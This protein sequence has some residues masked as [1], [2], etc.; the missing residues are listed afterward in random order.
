MFPA[1]AAAES[2]AHDGAPIAARFAE[3][4]ER[5]SLRDF[6]VVYFGNDWFAENRTSS[7]HVAAQLARRTRVLYVDCP[8]LRAPKATG[9]DLRKLQRKLLMA[10]S[11]PRQV[12]ERMWHITMPQVPFRRLPAI[13]DIN[14]ATG[15]F[16]VRRAMKQLGFDRTVSWFAVP[17]PG[18]LARTL[19]E[20]LAVYYCIDDY[21]ALPDVDAAAV[22]RMDTHLLRSADQVF[23]A[24]ELLL[25]SKRNLNASAVHAPHGVDVELFRNASDPRFAAVDAVRDLPRPVIGFY[26]LIES[27]IDLD[28]IAFLAQQRPQWTFLM[29]GRLA[30]DPGHLRDLPNVVFAGAQ[31]YESLPRWAKAFDVAI[32]PYRLT[33][34][35][36]NSN[37]L[38]L[39]EYLAT[40]KPVVAVSAP[41]IDR[42]SAHVRIAADSRQFLE[43]IEAALASDTPAQ[44]QARMQS[45]ADMGW[46]AR[47]DDVVRVVEER[48]TERAIR[49]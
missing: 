25:E 47:I 43:H 38:K 45:V 33:R 36:V 23:V 10:A 3:A 40:G 29:I 16:L 42:F 28:L 46:D 13:A 37:P 34:Q 5:A 44:Q 15:R 31:P 20:T 26:G 48:L 18:I 21:A 7:H 12:A 8:G 14:R 41:E 49:R 9:R 1:P 2:A 35:V 11:K 24:S 17:H 30:V 27:W 4:Q 19:D 22:T 32:I 39:R 6:D